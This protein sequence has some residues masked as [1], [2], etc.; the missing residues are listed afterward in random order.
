MDQSSERVFGW[1]DLTMG[2]GYIW[3]VFAIS[4]PSIICT[5]IFFFQ[6]IVNLYYISHLNNEAAL[7]AIGLGNMI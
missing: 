2:L 6:E 5:T 4:V 7:A 1:T 3:T